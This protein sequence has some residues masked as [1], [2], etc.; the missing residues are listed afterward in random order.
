MPNINQQLANI[1]LAR[2]FD[3]EKVKK[4]SAVKIEAILD[5]MSKEIIREISDI[6]PMGVTRTAYR[7]ERLNK[8]FNMAEQ[9]INS[10]YKNI[11][12]NVKRELFTL[13]EIESVFAGKAINSVLGVEMADYVL[14]REAL[15]ALASETLIQG[16]PSAEWWAK[17]SVELQDQFKRAMRTGIA[18]GETLNQLA[19]RVRGTQSPY[20]MGV[21][22]IVPGVTDMPIENLTKHAGIM[23]RAKRNA[24]A[25]VRTSYQQVMSSARDE[26][27]RKNDDVI[28]GTEHLS[29][30]DPRTTEI[31]QAYSGARWDLDGNPID[32]TVLPYPGPPGL[33]FGCRA[34][35]APLLRDLEDILG[36]SGVS[37]LPASTQSSFSR[38]GASGQISS[39]M[40]FNDWMKTL[41]KNEQIQIL[42]KKRQEQWE[43]G[44]MQLADFISP[45]N[46]VSL[47]LRAL[48]QKTEQGRFW[49]DD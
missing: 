16:A 13:A 3:L 17:Q 18:K 15:Q 28:R 24:E 12:G 9:T 44:R 20:V 21:R 41:D 14:S 38:T 25:L 48:Q 23:R 6:D 27:Y 40:N 29:V 30:L 1:Y 49:S 39:D 26:V 45:K 7:Q 31:C 11:A 43:S 46:K 34:V 8:L 22:E 4:S 36:V 2:A 37:E 5:D 42:G 19:A 47:E 33:H 10:R 35:H 32:G